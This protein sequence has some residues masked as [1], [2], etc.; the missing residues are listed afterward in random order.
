MNSKEIRQWGDSLNIPSDF[1][2]LVEEKY[3]LCLV[4]LGDDYLSACNLD[5]SVKFGGQTL[6]FCGTGRAKKLPRL[7]NVR[8]A[9]LSNPEAKRFSCALVGLK[10]ELAARLLNKL[11]KKNL[12]V[13]QLR[14]PESDLLSALEDGE[15][16]NRAVQ[17]C[18]PTE[19]A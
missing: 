4:L 17:K 19:T 14:D 11:S 3:D 5:A 10:G 7:A 15:L 16:T 6:L 8:V 13:E 9:T 2:K 1:R 12:T 18:R